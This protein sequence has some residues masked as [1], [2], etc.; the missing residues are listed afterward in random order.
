MVFGNTMDSHKTFLDHL[1]I[2][3]NCREVNT[4]NDSDV[5]IAFV[6][7]VS[8]AGTDISAAMEKIPEGKPVVLVVLH[9]TFDPHYIAPDS[10]RCVNEEK[11]FAVDCL[12]HEDQGLLRCLRNDD[13]IRAAKKH[14]T[15]EDDS[16]DVFR[17]GNCVVVRKI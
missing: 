7:I 9:H 10:R 6:P 11:V 14:L 2:S 16:G 8:R 17:G 13:A 12:Y 5:I 15:V 4:L 1:T 3:P